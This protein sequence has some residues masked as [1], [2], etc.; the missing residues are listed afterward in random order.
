[1]IDEARSPAILG[2]S[3]DP[4]HIGHLHLADAALHSGLFDSVFFVPA[5]KSP[6]KEDGAVASDSRRRQMVEAAIAKRDRMHMLSWEL[7]RR[8]TSYTIETVHKLRGLLPARVLPGLILGDDLLDGLER[9]RSV[10]ELVQSTVLT[11]GARATGYPAEDPRVVKLKS[12][13]ATV[14]VL[15]NAVLPISS[16]EIRRRIR[17][18]EAYR[19]LVPENVYE[20]IETHALYR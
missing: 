18:G 7:E 13:G 5:H 14:E 16:S 1:M 9:W 3:F 17:A 6:H 11:I 4:I 20:I 8:G 19:D 10:N 15:S 2:G 12:L